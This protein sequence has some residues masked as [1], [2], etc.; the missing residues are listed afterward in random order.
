MTTALAALLLSAT[1]LLLYELRS[2][3]DG[4]LQQL[5][6]QAELLARAS[7]PA[8]AGV[9]PQ[10]A[11]DML[12]LLRDQPEVHAAGL[13]DARGRLLAAYAA[14]GQSGP[15]PRLGAAGGPPRFVNQRIELRHPVEQNGRLLGTLV[16]A[17][18]YAVLPRLLDYLSILLLVVLAGLV[19]AG[20]VAQGLQR[21]I[22][23]PI[24]AIAAVARQV[25][26]TRDY[27]LRAPRTSHDEVGALVDAFNDMLRELG[28]QA[29]ALR[30]ADRRKDEYLAT[31][32]HELRNPLAPITTALDILARADGDAATRSRLLDMMQRQTGQLVRLI[33]ELMEAS[34]ISTG[35]LRLQL[36]SLDLVEVVRGA[37]ESVAPALLAGGQAL[38]VDWPPPV[39]LQADRLRL[40]Q[41]F[42]NL[43]SNGAKYTPAGGHIDIEFELGPGSV[44]VRVRDDGIG[45]APE[46]QSEVFEMFTRV[47]GAG[48][49]PGD[50]LGVGLPV[51]R[52][53]VRLHDGQLLLHSDG[54]GRGSVFTVLLP[55]AA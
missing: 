18:H 55:R 31:L 34:R 11:H 7:L 40:G 33:D 12:A 45:I 6:S 43:L 21:S 2:H 23:E 41:V 54:L 47:E 4:W 19:L 29:E 49:G 9:P 15:A 35:R 24:V 39:R 5:Q 46:R 17:A 13:Y 14:A 25:V 22:T 50:G 27:R 51:A 10:G 28:D 32:A 42:A 48:A 20:L 30:A 37:V 52:Q 26:V 3:R 8:A 38:R 1:V 36:E 44:A 16:V 53:L